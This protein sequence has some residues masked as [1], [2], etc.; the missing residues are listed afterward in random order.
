MVCFVFPAQN[1]TRLEFLSDMQRPSA[2]NP[3]P[4]STTPVSSPLDEALKF[5]R[6]GIAVNNSKNEGKGLI[7]GVEDKATIPGS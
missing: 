4:S 5:Y 2:F 7:E 3:P 6:V 1:D